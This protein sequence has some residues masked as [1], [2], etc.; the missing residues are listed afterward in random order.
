MLS[1]RIQ[2][3]PPKTEACTHRANWVH[4]FFCCC[5]SW[6]LKVNFLLDFELCFVFQLSRFSWRPVLSESTTLGF[7]QLLFGSRLSL[8][9]LYWLSIQL[10]CW[11]SVS[12]LSEQTVPVNIILFRNFP[13]ALENNLLHMES[14]TSK[15]F[16]HYLPLP[17]Q[18][19][20]LVQG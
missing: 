18:L 5:W 12:F 8:L 4:W 16:E 15:C 11:P 19:D 14:Q 20:P 13:F 6:N 9:E 1:K 2:R 3:H 17:L 7:S 10:L